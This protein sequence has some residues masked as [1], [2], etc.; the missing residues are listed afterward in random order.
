MQ[1]GAELIGKLIEKYGYPSHAK[2]KDQGQ[3]W[4]VADPVN[5]QSWSL[6]RRGCFAHCLRQRLGTRAI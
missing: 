2:D 5:E 4:V 6:A 3:V 1:Q